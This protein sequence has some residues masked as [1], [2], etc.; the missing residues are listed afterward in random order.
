MFT[1]T[2]SQPDVTFI[3]HHNHMWCA[4]VEYFVDFSI[5]GDKADKKFVDKKSGKYLPIGLL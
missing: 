4:P 2:H 1:Q 3:A 5:Y